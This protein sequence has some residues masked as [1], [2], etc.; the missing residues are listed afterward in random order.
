MLDDAGLAV[1][2][3]VLVVARD[4]PNLH[5][6]GAEKVM[7]TAITI[8][9]EQEV[10][11]VLGR[12]PRRDECARQRLLAITRRLGDLHVEGVE[13]AVADDPD[14]VDRL[15]RLPDDL[16]QGGPEIAGNAQVSRRAL[17]ARREYRTERLATRRKTLDRHAAAALQ[18]IWPTS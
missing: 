16:Q 5:A 12:L 11:A 2:E 7:K 8:A 1:D 9:R 15:Q 4:N 6:A 10:D 17:E 3:D 13:I 18:S 14:L